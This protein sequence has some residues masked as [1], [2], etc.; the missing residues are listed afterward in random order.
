MVIAALETGTQLPPR[1]HR[2]FRLWF[3]LGWPAFIGLVVV[4][5]LMVAKP[6]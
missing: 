4:F 3:L 2:L 5:Y 6:L 1:Y